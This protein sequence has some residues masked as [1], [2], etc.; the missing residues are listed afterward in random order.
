MF[1]CQFNALMRHYQSRTAEKSQQQHLMAIGNG[2]FSW[3]NNSNT[4]HQY[5]KRLQMWNASTVPTE[6][7]VICPAFSYGKT[8]VSHL[9]A[10]RR[11]MRR[12][13]LMPLSAL[14]L[15]LSG[16]SS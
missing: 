8:I 11:E 4:R 10:G 1:V 16:S 12:R 14:A 7:E 3:R 15:A 9:L 6:C 2:V 13:E 5:C